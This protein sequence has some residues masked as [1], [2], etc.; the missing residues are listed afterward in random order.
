[1]GFPDFVSFEI[2]RTPSR[3]RYLLDLHAA[4]ARLDTTAIRAGL[5]RVQRVRNLGVR[6]GDVALSGTYQE[7]LLLL[8]LSDTAA[9]T[10]RLDAVLQ[11][12]PAVRSDVLSDVPQTASLVRAMALRATLAAQ[13]G[14]TTVSHWWAR[15][16][17]ALWSDADPPLAGV[18]RSMRAITGER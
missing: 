16:V 14:D 11:N 2:H 8:V 1:M 5:E 17:L 12:L 18:V 13:A 6:P 7:T 10:R 4:A 3:G 15:N 9:A